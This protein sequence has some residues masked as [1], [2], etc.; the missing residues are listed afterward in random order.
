MFNTYKLRKWA[1]ACSLRDKN[2]CYMCDR[3]GRTEVH[4]IYP[5]SIF[6][7]KAYDLDNG[8]SLCKMCHIIVV[9]ASDTFDLR[10]WSKFTVLFNYAMRLIER[11]RFNDKYQHRI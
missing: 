10:N 5:K 4:H 2:T 9:H 7:D 11:K 6:P 3:V 8:I 1:K